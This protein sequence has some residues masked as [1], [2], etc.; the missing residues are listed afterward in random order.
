MDFASLAA[1]LKE[2][3]GRAADTDRAAREALQRC[4]QTDAQLQSTEVCSLFLLCHLL[5]RTNLPMQ[6]SSLDSTWATSG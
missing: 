4:A 1:R 2:G 6:S 3:E 5:V